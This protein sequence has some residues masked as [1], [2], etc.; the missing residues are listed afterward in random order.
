MQ[1]TQEADEDQQNLTAAEEAVLVDF[2]E[3]STAHGFPQT[4]PNIT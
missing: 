3:Q 4:H 1:S 2:L